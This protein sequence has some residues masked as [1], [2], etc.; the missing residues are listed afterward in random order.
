MRR[1]ISSIF[2]NSGCILLLAII[3]SCERS[4]LPEPFTE[5][6][7]IDHSIEADARYPYLHTHGD[8]V[9][10]SWQSEQEEDMTQLHM[11]VLKDGE[12]TQ[13]Q[14]VIRG[15]EWFVNW[16]DFP[17]VGSTRN[18]DFMISY[19]SSNGPGTFAYDLNFITSIEPGEWQKPFVPHADQT[20]T[21]HG[22]ASIEPYGED[23]LLTIW[24]DGR[25]MDEPES[26]EDDHDSHDAHGTG[27]MS[28][29]YGFVDPAT[30]RVTGKGPLDL[31]V[32]ECCPTSSTQTEE[33]AIFFYRD[34]AEDETRNISVIRYEFDRQEW[35]EP[36]Y[37]YDDGWQIG[38]CP[39]NGP[40]ADSYGNT[41]AAAWFTAPEDEP[42]V[43]V[44]FSEDHGATFSSPVNLHIDNALGRVDVQMINRETALV[45]W[46]D[47][48]DGETQ[49]VA[50][51]VDKSGQ[52]SAP[53]LLA[54]D[55][56]LA[57]RSS[58][59][60]RI[61]KSGS[62]IYMGWTRPGDSNE[63]QLYKGTLTL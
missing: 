14:D 16:A 47:Q 22:F 62:T 1:D 34:R 63:L 26:S 27:D 40:A 28:L 45:T 38:G 36:E 43:R 54:T 51:L 46:I 29:M 3:L 60:P 15:P 50:R 39:V 10:V 9:L 41:T 32:C 57:E 35:S 20:P 42:H 21:E 4:S 25:Q 7:P 17:V 49:L 5:I 31:R 6:T 30:G 24:L 52:K 23:Q 2:I 33:A 58:G 12:F 37:L 53:Q 18:G 8:S 59:F 44:A 55:D 56:Y 11:S 19:M 48:V 13:T 61:T